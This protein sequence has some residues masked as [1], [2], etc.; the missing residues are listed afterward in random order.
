MSRVGKKPLILPAGVSATVAENRVVIKG[1]KGTLEQAFDPVIQ[2]VVENGQVILK[3]SGDSKK[4][5][6]LHGLY[7]SLFNNMVVGVTQGFS[8]SLEVEGVGYKIAKSGE[9]LVLSLG[10]SHPVEV[11]PPKGIV[12]EV[13]GK[14]EIIIRGIDK[15]LVGQMAANI[16]KIKPVEPYKGKGIKYKG[17]YVR[18]K[19]GKVVKATGA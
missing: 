15:A 1:P 13:G 2:V 4:I 11:N 8:K 12:L 10:F 5:R 7:R 3:R 18:R 14:N 6:A 19:A 9:K 16:R 17:E